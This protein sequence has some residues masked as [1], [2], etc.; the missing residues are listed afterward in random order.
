M[1]LGVIG[2]RTSVVARSS[3]GKL[4][5]KAG[6]GFLLANASPPIAQGTF[7]RVTWSAHLTPRKIPSPPVT[8]YP[9]LP[10]GEQSDLDRDATSPLYAV[11]HDIPDT[12]HQRQW[13]S[14]IT[15]PALLCPRQPGE[16]RKPVRRP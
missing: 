3:G 12:N 16:P 14:G 6:L 1:A 10:E 5:S 4:C 2:P 7:Y 8:E 11:E 13:V 9:R 15:E